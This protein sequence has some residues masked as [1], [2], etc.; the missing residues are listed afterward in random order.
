[1]K[2]YF[3]AT[4]ILVVMILSVFAAPMYMTWVQSVTIHAVAKAVQSYKRT[5]M[6]TYVSTERFERVK[7][8]NRALNQ[9]I[10]DMIDSRKVKKTEIQ[11]RDKLIEIQKMRIMELSK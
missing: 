2:K 6:I 11:N 3:L 9:I 1:M 7:S 5:T 8:S 4:S 10:L